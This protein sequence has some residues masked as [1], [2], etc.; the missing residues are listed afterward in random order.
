MDIKFSH[1]YPKLWGQ[2]RA[3]LIAVRRLH[4]IQRNDAL[5]TYDTTWDD[6]GDIGTYPLPEGDLIQ[7]IFLGDKRIPFC[8]LRRFTTQKWSYYQD[9]VGQY[10][11]IVLTSVQ[12][13]Q[14]SK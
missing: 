2:K 6:N 4:T 5:L 12:N 9:Q 3:E 1:S 14:E 11:D 7:L 8:T 10:F 13:N